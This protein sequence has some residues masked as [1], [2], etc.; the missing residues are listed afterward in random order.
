MLSS[1][2][3]IP[4][5]KRTAAAKTKRRITPTPVKSPFAT[6]HKTQFS[7]PTEASN[8]SVLL[9]AFTSSNSQP[10]ADLNKAL[11]EDRR[12]IQKEINMKRNRHAKNIAGQN[13]CSRDRHRILPSQG[14]DQTEKK[15]VITSGSL[16]PSC[17][18]VSNMRQ[19]TI[20]SIQGM[21][22]QKQAQG[23]CI[24]LP[25]GVVTADIC[26]GGKADDFS[27]VSVSSRPQLE[28]Q[29]ASTLTDP[30][31]LDVLSAVYSRV[32]QGGLAHIPCSQV[33]SRGWIFIDS[34]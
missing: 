3:S 24:Q 34:D 6:G 23:R 8:T 12:E 30:N 2:M 5:H 10:T 9:C 19:G 7:P 31:A 21:S 1:S 14:L 16:N 20:A 13:A 33:F 26:G 4:S 15:S 27:P 22:A 28:H 29:E 32:I 25:E 11:K 18:L 17:M